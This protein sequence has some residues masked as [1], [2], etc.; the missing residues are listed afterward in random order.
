MVNKEKWAEIIKDFHEKGLPEVIT[1]DKEIPTGLKLKRAISIIGPRRAGKTY[2]MFYLIKH[3]SEINSLD[4][5][6]YINFE[7][8]D[9]GVLSYSDLTNMLEAYYEIYPQNK[10]QKIWLFLDEI[11]N[12]SQWERFVRTCLDEDVGVFLSGSSSKMLSKEIAT[13]MAGRNLSYKILPFSFR[14]FL[15]ARKFEEKKYYSSSEKS[16]LINLL[17]EYIKFGSYPEAVIYPENREK[18]LMD[19]F[20]T[21]IYRDVIERNKIRNGNVLKMLIKALITSKEFSAHK[22]FN[23]LKSQGVKISKNSVYQYLDFLSDAFFIFQLKKAGN[24]NRQSEQSMPK[25]YFIDNGLLTINGVDDRGRLIENLVFTELFRREDSIFYYQNERKEEVDFVIKDGRKVVELIQVCYDVSNIN[26]FD[27][28]IKPLIKVGKE[29]NCKKLTLI[30]MEVEKEE[31][32]KGVTIKFIP[33][34]KWLLS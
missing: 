12:V 18:I 25:I 10:K 15:R 5:I 24:S 23:F 30:N 22:F 7:R 3:L 14:E 17:L 34:W 20:E 16:L 4:R 8:A 27:R 1:R 2:E 29:F 21:A 19:I 33:L 6:V 32:I 9:L 26:T 11:Q 31:K 28:E 13:S